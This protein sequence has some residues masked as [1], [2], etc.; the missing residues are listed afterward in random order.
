MPKPAPGYVSR[1][2]LAETFR[3]LATDALVWKLRHGGLTPLAVEVATAELQSRGIDPMNHPLDPAF[4][5]RDP[6]PEPATAVDRFGNVLLGTIKA[7]GAAGA[8]LAIVGAAFWEFGDRGGSS[9]TGYLFALVLIFTVLLTQR[10]PIVGL[11]LAAATVLFFVSCAA[12]FH[13]AGG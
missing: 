4:E 8:S 13:W 7:V 11:V 2:Q 3:A 6:L 1:E 10:I 5:V 9:G 12:N